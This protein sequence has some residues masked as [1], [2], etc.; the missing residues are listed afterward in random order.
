MENNG[1]IPSSQLAL[2]PG[3]TPTSHDDSWLNPP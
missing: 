1:V 3:M 2:G